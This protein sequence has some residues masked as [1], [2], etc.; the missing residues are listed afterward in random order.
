VPEKTGGA[1]TFVCVESRSNLAIF[2]GGEG[3]CRRVSLPR[4]SNTAQARQDSLPRGKAAGVDPCPKPIICR[5]TQQSLCWDCLRRGGARRTVATSLILYAHYIRAL[6]SHICASQLITLG[7]LFPLHP[8]R[9]SRACRP[10][11]IEPPH[12][13][14]MAWHDELHLLCSVEMFQ[15]L[16]RFAHECEKIAKASALP[17]A[18]RPRCG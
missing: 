14:A 9:E 8:P 7:P 13:G 12:H 18:R 16:A 10:D 3:A 4:T 5:A 11:Q 6:V 1:W 17:A 15:G 2:S